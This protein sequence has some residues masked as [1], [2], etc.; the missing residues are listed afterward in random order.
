MNISPVT[1]DGKCVR[2]EPL[3]LDLHWEGLCAIG[4]DADLWQWTLSK[5]ETRD[6]LRKYLETALEEQSRGVSLP[7]TTIDRATGRIAGC[8]RFGSIDRPN[9]R[10]EIGWTWVGRPFQRSHVNTEAKYLMLTHAFETWGCKRVELKTHEKNERSRSAM[11]RIGCTY[12]GLLRN[13][14]TGDVGTRNTA[15]FS[16]IDSEWPAVKARLEQMM[17]REPTRDAAPASQPS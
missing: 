15:M 14:Q 10:V 5:I 7:F 8:T 16:I 3:S 6:D 13:Y 11:L 4:L 9:R 12:E 17:R 2:M 1:L